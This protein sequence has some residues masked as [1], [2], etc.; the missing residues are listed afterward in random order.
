V[1]AIQMTAAVVNTKILIVM[2]V[3]MMCVQILDSVFLQENERSENGG[4]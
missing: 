4:S 3:C 1:I 2:F